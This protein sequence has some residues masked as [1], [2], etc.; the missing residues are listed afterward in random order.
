MK[1]LMTSVLFCIVSF[2]EAS[3]CSLKLSGVEKEVNFF[4]VYKNRVQGTLIVED[5]KVY[6]LPNDYLLINEVLLN[7][8][9]SSYRTHECFKVVKDKVIIRQLC[10]SNSYYSSDFIFISGSHLGSFSVECSF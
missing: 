9:L 5:I 6:S 8:Y 2:S 4:N 3:I 1:V 7:P 10:S